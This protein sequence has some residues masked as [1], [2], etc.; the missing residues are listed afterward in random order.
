MFEVQT[1]CVPFDIDLSQLEQVQVSRI[2][3]SNEIWKQIIVNLWKQRQASSTYQYCTTRSFQLIFGLRSGIPPVLVDF[4]NVTAPSRYCH[5]AILESMPYPAPL[6]F[7]WFFVRWSYL[8]QSKE[9][10]SVHDQ[11]DSL[12]LSCIS[13]SLKSVASVR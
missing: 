3:A 7:H 11:L 13:R 6:S 1:V 2:F 5:I 8:S 4:L 9:I 10:C 12:N